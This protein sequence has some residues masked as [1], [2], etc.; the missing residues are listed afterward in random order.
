ME[1]NLDSQR[2]E[3]AQMLV[4]FVAYVAHQMLSK[5]LGT[6]NPEA[7]ERK[8]KETEMAVTPQT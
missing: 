8:Q 5:R 3:L 7:N 2:K 1:L 6:Q 4:L